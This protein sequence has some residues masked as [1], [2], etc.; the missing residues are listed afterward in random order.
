MIIIPLSLI[1]QL[2]EVQSENE[3]W[4]W[5]WEF[6]DNSIWSRKKEVKYL[7]ASAIL[8]YH[9]LSVVAMCKKYYSFCL[10]CKCCYWSL[11]LNKCL[12][13]KRI[14]YQNDWLPPQNQTE[15]LKVHG[16]TLYNFQRQFCLMWKS[17]VQVKSTYHVIFKNLIVWK[18]HFRVA[19][20]HK[21]I[22]RTYSL[23]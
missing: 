16:T 15:I 1:F 19:S 21:E 8:C 9:V 18:L 11:L 10:T 13:Q 17:C 20:L 14:T 5:I 12:F 22:H 6:F 23:Q 4:K 2:K 3:M 7:S